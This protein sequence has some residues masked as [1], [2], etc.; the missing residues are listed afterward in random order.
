MK[1]YGTKL[2]DP[3]SKLG[4]KRHTPKSIDRLG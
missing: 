1:K 4:K 2:I 3:K